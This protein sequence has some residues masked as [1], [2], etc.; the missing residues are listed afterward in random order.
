MNL[1]NAMRVFLAV[2]EDQSL[3]EAARSLGLSPPSVTRLLNDLEDWIGT[4]LFL[5]TTRHVSLTEAGERFLPRCRQIVEEIDA[6]KRDADDESQSPSG[7]LRVTASRF[8]A[9]TLIA[10]VL[11]QF[12]SDFPR[13]SVH[14]EATDSALN[15]VTD[16]IDLAIRVGEP[17]DSQLIQRKIGEVALRLTATP[18]FIVQHE[19]IETPEDL[20]RVPCIVDEV[21]D[22]RADWPIGK[23]LRVK[24]P[25]KVSDGEIVRDMTLAGIG[26]SFLPDFFVH[27]DLRS[28]ALVEVL[29][30]IPL[31]KFGVFA[32]FPPRPFISKSARLLSDRIEVKFAEKLS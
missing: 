18:E 26:V 1:H 7:T 19:P 14:L 9:R 12:L 29:P 20:E 15:I 31:P 4:A 22:Y 27:E 5:R 30:G 8:L 24:G 23:G 28:G 6:I 2:A 3:S 10:P 16:R 13:M 11:P 21:P 17:P 25:I 32:V